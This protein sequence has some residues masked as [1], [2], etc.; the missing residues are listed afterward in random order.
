MSSNLLRK[1]AMDAFAP[2]KDKDVII[3]KMSNEI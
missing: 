3:E 2:V 1:V